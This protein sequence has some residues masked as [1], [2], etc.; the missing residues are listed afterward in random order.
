MHRTIAF[1]SLALLVMLMPAAAEN[2]YHDLT[3]EFYVLEDAADLPPT[4]FIGLTG[5]AAKVIY[6]SLPGEAE[7]NECM[8]GMMKFMPDTG[9][10]NADPEAGDYFCSFSIDLQTGKFGGGESC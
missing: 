5:E 8:G 6:D 3:G 10:C 9:Y 7:V 2:G 4:M 1:G